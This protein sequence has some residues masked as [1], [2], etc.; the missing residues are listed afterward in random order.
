MSCS[1]LTKYRSLFH[2][3]LL[4]SSATVVSMTQHAWCTVIPARSGFVMDVETHL[5]GVLHNYVALSFET[6]RTHDT[7]KASNGFVV[8][9]LI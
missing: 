8:V 6:I 4:V 1:V 7:W 5:A 9:M 3:L 2:V